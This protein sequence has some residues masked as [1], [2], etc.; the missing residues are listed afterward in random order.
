MERDFLMVKTALR[1]K[2]SMSFMSNMIFSENSSQISND[3]ISAL[4]ENDR[5]TLELIVNLLEPFYQG[6]IIFKS[7]II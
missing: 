5:N 1:I 6:F 7:F 4:N 3:H 2:K